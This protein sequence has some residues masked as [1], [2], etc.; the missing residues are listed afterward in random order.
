MAENSHINIKPIFIER[1]ISGICHDIGAPTRH[2]VQ[3]SQMLNQAGADSNLEDKHKRWLMLINDGGVKIQAMLSSLSKLS[4]LSSSMENPVKINL[5]ELFERVISQHKERH[6]K[7]KNHLALTM[8]DN[9]PV[10]NGY[11][12]HW[13][14]LFYSV[15]EN[16]LIFQPKA[17]NHT[18]EI[19]VIC[20]CDGNEVNFI[21]QDNGIGATFHQRNDMSKPF[22]RLN[23]VDDYPGIGMGLAYCAYIAELN[24]ARLTFDESPLGGLSVNY[25]QPIYNESS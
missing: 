4:Y 9:W 3:F 11:E 2:I 19:D 5:K 1:L 24:D 17:P 22:K 6:S 14:Q 13:H 18:V 7:Y 12:E 23:A 16:A 21:V 8:N 10:I 15:L 25:C 20:E